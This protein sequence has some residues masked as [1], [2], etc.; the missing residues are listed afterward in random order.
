MVGQIYDA[1]KTSGLMAAGTVVLT[2]LASGFDFYY[3][4][5]FF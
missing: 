1:E 3:H 4:Y 2:Y 5:S